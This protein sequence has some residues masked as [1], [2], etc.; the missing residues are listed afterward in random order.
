MSHTFQLDWV[1]PL[2]ATTAKATRL[3]GHVRILGSDFHVNADEV[4][5]KNGFQES[6]EGDTLITEMQGII[7]GRG[8]TVRINQRRYLLVIS[9]FQDNQ[10]DPT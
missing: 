9:P 3:R 5:S 1:Q 2:H 4:T 8:E 10:N 6:V 7:G